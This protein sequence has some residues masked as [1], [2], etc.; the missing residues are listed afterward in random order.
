M[1]GALVR[2]FK[3]P[4]CNMR[5]LSEGVVGESKAWGEGGQSSRNARDVPLDVTLDVYMCN[6]IVQKLISDN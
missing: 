1:V 4:V 2:A 3:T 5:E 6:S